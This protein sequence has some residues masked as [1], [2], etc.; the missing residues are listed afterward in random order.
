MQKEYFKQVIQEAGE[1][2]R[3]HYGWKDAPEPWCEGSRLVE[4]QES[5]TLD[6]GAPNF[7]NQGYALLSL[8][9][10]EPTLV[11]GVWDAEGRSLRQHVEATKAQAVIQN[12]GPAFRDR[13]WGKRPYSTTH[14]TSAANI[15]LCTDK[16]WVTT[17]LPDDGFRCK[18]ADA[19]FLNDGDVRSEET[20][21]QER[22]AFMG[23][24]VT[25][26]HVSAGWR[27]EKTLEPW[28]F[29]GAI[30]TPVMETAQLIAEQWWVNKHTLNPK[31][32]DFFYSY[33]T[34]LKALLN[35]LYHSARCARM[36]HAD[37][38]AAADGYDPV[39]DTGEPWAGAIIHHKDGRLESI[40]G[41]VRR[42]TSRR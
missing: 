33:A 37:A 13:P 42:K 18:F 2:I 17:L 36:S 21:L 39:A 5:C 35:C 12:Y 27:I 22:T 10:P 16:L 11:G 1:K 3:L 41:D 7:E 32:G 38:V 8:S 24:F 31:E 4:R 34:G 28:S 20:V 23:G 6:R 26:I 9:G 40:P 29:G 30:K 14:G 15:G 19:K 25:L